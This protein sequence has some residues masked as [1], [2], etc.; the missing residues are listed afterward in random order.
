MLFGLDCS[1]PATFAESAIYILHIFATK[2]DSLL[3]Q[4]ANRLIFHTRSNK[5]ISSNYWLQIGIQIIWLFSI[6]LPSSP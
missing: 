1:D 4:T 2:R 6:F 3:R 5:T